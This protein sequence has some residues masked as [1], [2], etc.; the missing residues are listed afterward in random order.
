MTDRIYAYRDAIPSIDIFEPSLP[1]PWIHY[2]SNGELHAFVSQAGGGFAWWKDAIARR[3]SRYRM[4]HLPADR[5]GFYLYIA[6]EGHK[7]FTPTYQPVCTK[8]DNWRCSFVPGK[9]I[10]NCEKDGLHAEQRQYITPDE[11]LLVWDVQILNQTMIDRVLDLTAY[12]E[13]SQLDWMNE[14]LYGYYWRHMLKTWQTDDGL[15]YY[16][17]Q[18]REANEYLPAPLVF[19]GSSEEMHSFSTDRTAFMGAYRDE[20]NPKAIEHHACGN[21]TILSGE[22]CFAIQVRREIKAG[23]TIRL[24]WF[25]GIAKNGLKEFSNADRSARRMAAL[26]RNSAWL[27][28][29]QEKLS[30]SWQSYLNK[31]SCCLPDEQL[32]RMISVWGPINCMN[33]ARYSRAVNVE[34]PGIRGL[35]FRDTAQDML[36]MCHRAPAMVKTMM[37]QLLSKQFPSGNAVHLIPLNPYEL[38]DA[39]TR[40]DSHLWLPILLYTYLTETGDFDV[41]TENVP[42][43]SPETKLG[44]YG[45]A[46]VW[47]HMMSAVR[48]TET[49]LGPHGLPQ[50]LKGDWNDIIGKFSEKGKGESV[51]AAMQ[52]LVCLRLLK[53]IAEYQKLPETQKI[54]LLAEKQKAA[55][56]ENAYNGAWWY[57]CFNDNGEPIGGPDSTYGK[58]W[59][60]PQSWAVISGVGTHDQQ[61]SGMRQVDS[62]LKTSVGLRLISPG[63]ATYPE[64]DDPFTG[65][66]PGNGENGAIFCHANAWAVIAQALLGDGDRAWEYYSLLA[67]QKALERVGINVYKAE[68]Y[69][70]ASNIVGPDNPKHGWANVTHIT[71]TAA[72]MEI[73]AYHYLLGIRPKLGGLQ[74]M[75][76]MPKQWRHMEAIYDYRGTK[77]RLYVENPDSASCGVRRMKVDG[78]DVLDNY[79]ALETIMG[80]Q[81]LRIDVVLGE[82][83]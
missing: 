59:L 12:V 65:Y 57:R 48:F 28:L 43:L 76:V 13:L 68:P 25:L 75:P 27:D 14:Q 83:E 4:H 21:E 52:Y 34:A 64:T 17:Y 41:L 72:W 60:N 61:L 78:M 70:W 44:E 63:F 22:P 36:P 66:N 29:Q 7:P 6:E 35:G 51:F 5:P 8:L 23:E 82:K 26:G 71:G 73:A 79:V 31:G 16:L 55:I 54:A 10:F 69:A 47:E 1:Q 18:Y 19:F 49:H 37:K 67:P 56:E 81:E 20:S 15:L 30:H 62:I 74:I 42:Y 38:P 32:T 9:A 39:R 2:L 77:V 33:T 46:T 45:T 50:T 3:L 11:N 53:E 40:C 58:L 80:K 24:S